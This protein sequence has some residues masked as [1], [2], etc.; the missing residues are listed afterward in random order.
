M[1]RQAVSLAIKTPRTCNG[2]CEHIYAAYEPNIRNRVLSLHFGNKGLGH[3]LGAL[4]LITADL[5]EL[6]EIAERN[7]AW[8]D[9]GLFAMSL[10]YAL[11]AARLGT[12]MLNWSVDYKHDQKFRKEFDIPD[13][14]AI[15]TFVGVGHLPDTFEVAASPGPSVD[16]VLSVLSAR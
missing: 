7:Q 10:V 15:V 6:Y 5:R 12:C 11:H 9:G 3:E 13:N 16:E 8:I 2:S 4:L 14:E 1:V